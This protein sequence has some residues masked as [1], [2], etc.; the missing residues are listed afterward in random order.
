LKVGYVLRTEKETIMPDA[1]PSLKIHSAV[2]GSLL[3]IG[4]FS[5]VAA[6]Q[7]PKSSPPAPKPFSYNYAA[8]AKAAAVMDLDHPDAAGMRAIYAARR[9]R[10]LDSMPEGAMLL[11]SVDEN[12]P[13]H[14]EYQVPQSENHD[15]E[16]LTGLA[17]LDSYDS[18]LLLIPAVDGSRAVLYTSAAVEDIK[19]ATGID[20]V[21]PYA[22]MEQDFSIAI[23]TYRDWRITQIRRWPVPAALAKT[24]ASGPKVLYVNYPRFPRLSEP[25]P[26]RFAFFATLQHYSPSIELRDSAE[27]MDPIRELHDAY[28]LACLRRAVQITG[29]GIVEGMRLVRPGL[30]ETQV[31]ETLDYVYRYHGGTLGFPTEVE[32]SPIAPG[33]NIREV[34]EG[35][36]AFVSRS[37]EDPIRAGG[38]VHVD[39]GASFLDHSSDIQRVAPVDGHFTAEQRHL[40]E[41]ALRVQKTV[42]DH[43]KP[44]AKWWDLHN[45]AV[46]MLHEEGNF[47]QY[48]KY[49]IGH[50][51]GMEVHD[52]GDYEKPMQPGMAMAIEQGIVLPDGLHMQLEDNVIVTETGHDWISQSIPIEPD[53]VEKMMQTPSSFAAFANKPWPPPAK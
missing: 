36:I 40:Y 1:K 31:M 50:F 23:T 39:T 33:R 52:E 45:L 46:Q 20:D 18:A 41:L 47:D 43:I 28:D 35:Y 37:G 14:L 24:W 32:E 51:I 30:T 29:D 2:L 3:T 38:V 48:Y 25:E 17:G 5:G 53:D 15:F 21:R 34:P 49:G 11:F 8:E 10:V 22:E 42:I 13:R 6:A 44:G 4:V 26:V 7:T 27:V 12:Q 9:K 16:Y 19:A